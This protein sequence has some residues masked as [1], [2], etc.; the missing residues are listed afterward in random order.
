MCQYFKSLMEKRDA[1]RLMVWIITRTPYSCSCFVHL[2]TER[3]EWI[4]WI[5]PSREKWS[6]FLLQTIMPVI[7]WSSLIAQ[8]VKSLPAMWETWI[9]SLGQEDPLEKEMA[10]HSSILAWRIPWTKKPGGYST[11]GHKELDMTQWLTHMPIREVLVRINESKCVD[12]TVHR[13]KNSAER[14]L[15]GVLD[16]VQDHSDELALE[17]WP[18]GSWSSIIIISTFPLLTRTKRRI[19]I[20]PHYKNALNCLQRFFNRHWFIILETRIY[21]EGITPL[22]V[23]IV[24][25]K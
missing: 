5:S 13:F 3:L 14:I 4:T 9:Q 15:E 20:F 10:T 2:L 24:L 17:S 18:W 25:W 22:L 12:L 21:N 19:F 16:T 6:F 23:W 8:M 7:L 1:K 11:W